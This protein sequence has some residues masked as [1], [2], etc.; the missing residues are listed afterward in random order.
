M[1]KRTA[2]DETGQGMSVV[3]ASDIFAKI[4]GIIGESLDD[5]H[6]DEI[7]VVSWSWGLSASGAIAPGMVSFH[8]FNFTHHV[9]KASPTLM[10]ACTTGEHIKDATVTVR[11]SGTGQQEFLII[12]MADVMITSVAP[13]ANG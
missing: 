3:M 6:K 7:E 13:S 10:M 12:R 5:K 11:K 8:D 1:R 2:L 9:D 4:G